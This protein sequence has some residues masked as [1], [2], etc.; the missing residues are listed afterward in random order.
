VKPSWA[1]RACRQFDQ[2]M[3]VSRVSDR[4]Q[5]P[6]S[7]AY[8]ARVLRSGS[9]RS[10]PLLRRAGGSLKMM[11]AILPE[12]EENNEPSLIKETIYT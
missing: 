9:E 2:R 3:M 5:S 11:H 4:R 7:E 10:C 1:V 8:I 12:K 6:Q